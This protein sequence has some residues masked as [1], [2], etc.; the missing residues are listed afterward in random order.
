MMKPTILI[1]ALSVVLTGSL[2]FNFSEQAK[3]QNTMALAMTG[4]REAAWIVTNT[5]ELIYC[6]WDEF[7]PRRDQRASCR[8]MDK[9]NVD[10]L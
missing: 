3:A 6:W 2:Y 4:D 8:K 9:W 1:V 7:P 10:K 5:N